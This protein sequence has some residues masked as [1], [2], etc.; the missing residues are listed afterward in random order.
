[1]ALG[2]LPEEPPFSD[3][4]RDRRVLARMTDDQFNVEVLFWLGIRETRG[5]AQLELARFVLGSVMQTVDV[6]RKSVLLPESKQQE[7]TGNFAAITPGAVRGLALS[8]LLSSQLPEL[9]RT[10]AYAG[11]NPSI[12]I[13]TNL[14]GP[15][16]IAE[17]YVRN[18]CTSGVLPAYDPE[19]QLAWYG[20]G[21]LSVRAKAECKP[22]TDFLE[23][24]HGVNGVEFDAPR[25]ITLTPY[26]M[27]AYVD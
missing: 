12:G 2:K 4:L 19:L 6:L 7:L 23:R 1:M 15:G 20:D 26:L 21:E 5:P 14:S 9:V 24:Y 10:A 13:D 22:T 27:N 18:D 16:P 25:Y 11:K 3:F 17:L 8:R